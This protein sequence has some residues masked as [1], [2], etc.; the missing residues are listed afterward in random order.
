[1][2]LLVPLARCAALGDLVAQRGHN[3]SK[4]RAT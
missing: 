1:M 2:N 4:F 3:G